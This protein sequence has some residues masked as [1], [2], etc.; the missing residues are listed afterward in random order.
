MI[1]AQSGN[2]EARDP[3]VGAL[4]LEGS[5]ANRQLRFLNREITYAGKP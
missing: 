2:A 5:T 3:S 4:F 1:I